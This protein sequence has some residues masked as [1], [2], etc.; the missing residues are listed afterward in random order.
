MSNR[1]LAG[2]EP[3]V[4][5]GFCLQSCPTYLSTGDEADSPRGRIVLIKGLLQGRLSPR[6][7]ELRHHLNRCLGCRACETSCPSGVSYGPALEQARAVLSRSQPVPA[8]ARMVNAIMADTRLRRPI[9]GAARMIRRLTPMLAGGSRLGM[10][11]GM[12]A[13]TRQ[14]RRMNASRYASPRRYAPREPGRADRAVLFTGCIMDSLLSHVHRAT[15]RTLLANGFSLVTAPEQVCCGALHA[16]T[17]QHGEARRLA[18]ANVLAFATVPDATVVVNSA[19]C[20][21]ILKE[22]GELL[23][24]DPLEGEARSFASRVRDVSEILVQEGPRGGASVRFK[25]AYDPPCHLMHAQRV[26]TTPVDMLRAVPGLDLVVHADP[27]QCCGSAGSY[28]LTEPELSRTV[29]DRKVKS[30]M[31]ADPDLV[32]SGNPGCIMQIGAGLRAAGS[33]ISVVHPVEILDLSYSEAGLYD[34]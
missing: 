16:H 7:A 32:A 20:G 13:A 11:F 1:G 21:A 10:A 26:V 31:D 29:I 24:G 30:L 17:G 28:S 14:L 8:T 4:H 27:D 34:A 33:Q 19:G 5:C 3:C 6:E 22:Y 12:I 18:R 25:V 23:H 9:L 15:E 2:L